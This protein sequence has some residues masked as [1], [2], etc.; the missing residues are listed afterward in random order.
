MWPKKTH[1]LAPLLALTSSKVKW[2]WTEECQKAFEQ[3]KELIATENLVK[4]S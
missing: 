2:N 3:M 1:L 4:L